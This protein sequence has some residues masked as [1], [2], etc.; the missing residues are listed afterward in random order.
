MV[1]GGQGE[2]SADNMD[3][4]LEA[5]MGGREGIRRLPWESG[6]E[7][8][9]SPGVF[10]TCPTNLGCVRSWVS[11]RGFSVILRIPPDECKRHL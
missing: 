5:E 2:L 11:H 4:V 3:D 9:G 6:W 7:V 1:G 8:M 10:L